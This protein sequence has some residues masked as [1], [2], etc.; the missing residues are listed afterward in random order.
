MMRAGR[1]IA[2]RLQPYWRCLENPRYHRLGGGLRPFCRHCGA[3]ERRRW[4]AAVLSSAMAWR[5]SS[6]GYVNKSRTFNVERPFARAIVGAVDFADVVPLSDRAIYVQGKK[7]GS[8]N[9]SLFDGNARLIG[10]L[11]LEIVL[12]TVKSSAA[13][14]RRHRQ[15]KYSSFFAPRSDRRRWHRRRCGD[16]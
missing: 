2:G 1:N 10:V 15:L 3:A 8:T 4:I 14:P 9:V 5:S 16:R 6:S 13:D 7:V 11:D 12:D